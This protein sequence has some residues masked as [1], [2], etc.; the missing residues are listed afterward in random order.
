[1]TAVLHTPT[2]I[3][4]GAGF[5]ANFEQTGVDFLPI[6]CLTTFGVFVELGY[7]PPHGQPKL[8]VRW[9][10]PNVFSVAASPPGRPG[11]ETK[12]G[13]ISLDTEDRAE[14]VCALSPVVLQL[15]SLM[16]ASRFPVDFLFVVFSRDCG[17]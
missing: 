1:M 8:S 13:V 5:W 17:G 11:P 16:T 6:L 3:L 2:P 7:L 9:M 15:Y 10:S 4:R 12:R 14:A